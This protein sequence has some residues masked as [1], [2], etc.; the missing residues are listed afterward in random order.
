[1][2]SAAGKKRIAAAQRARWKK[3]KTAKTT[4][5][6][7]SYM[8]S[9]LKKVDDEIAKRKADVAN[10]VKIREVLGSLA[11]LAPGL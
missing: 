5:A 4:S 7:G 6:N 8:T 11:D 3:L 2:I 10:L 9:A 1:M